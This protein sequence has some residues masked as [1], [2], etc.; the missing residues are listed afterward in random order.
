MTDK[1][2]K[3]VCAVCGKDYDSITERNECETKCLKT[4]RKQ[5]RQKTDTIALKKLFY[6]YIEYLNQ[7]AD[8]VSAIDAETEAY[9]SKYGLVFADRDVY[10]S[11]MNL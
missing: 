2:T 6:H 1:P 5:E 4:F 3:Y 7:C 10:N 9:F 8:I 11:F